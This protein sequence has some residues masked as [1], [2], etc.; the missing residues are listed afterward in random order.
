MA[1]L[2]QMTKQLFQFSDRH[3]RSRLLLVLLLLANVGSFVGLSVAFQIGR[4][5]YLALGSV[6]TLGLLLLD[7]LVMLTW[8]TESRATRLS[9]SVDP[10]LVADWKWT[11]IALC[12][13]VFAF[14]TAGRSLVYYLAV[15]SFF[16]ALLVR[17]YVT[18]EVKESVVVELGVLV[19][20]TA[21]MLGAETLSVAYYARTADTIYHTALATRIAN[22][23]TLLAIAATR[24]DSLPAYH[25]M[26]ALGID[27]TGLPPRAFT[28]VF[29]SLAFAV[30]IA[31]FYVV[32][33]NVTESQTAGL[34]GGV[35]VAVNPEFIYWGTQSHVQSLSFVFLSILL[36]FLSKVADDRGY[37]LASV[38]LFAVWVM[39]H[40]L[41]VFMAIVLVGGPVAFVFVLTK[42]Q[43]SSF[44]VDP[45]RV[46]LK[47][48]ALLVGFTVVYW[49]YAGIFRTPISW[50]TEHSPGSKGVESTAILIQYYSDPVELVTQALPTIIADLHY[51]FWI[52]LTGLSLWV[53]FRSVDRYHR[54]VPVLVFSLLMA[55][56]YYFPN[57]A[58]VPLRGFAALTRWGVMSLPFLVP[59]I[60]LAL[61]KLKPDLTANSRGAV[62]VGVA[63]ALIVVSLTSG[64][65]NPAITDITGYHK[66]AQSSLDDDTVEAVSFTMTHAPPDSTIRGSSLV[67][68]YARFD[69]WER[70]IDLSRY[71][72]SR[73]RVADGELKSDPGL[74][75]VQVEAFRTKGIKVALENPDSK[76]YEG[77]DDI[78]VFTPVTADDV[79][80]DRGQQNVVYDGDG[81]VITY[82]RDAEQAE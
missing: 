19:A 55:C 36:V 52:A 53:I 9:T 77:V 57:P 42:L 5:R 8:N 72:F 75:V 4:P 28:A 32:I 67:P 17:V 50:L 70:G 61:V 49:T 3:S 18:A 23:D 30:T 74:N 56:V 73:V 21:L 62:A 63:F 65:A 38:V 15:A 2:W 22:F 43:N 13:S 41:S 26:V 82:G 81:T 76:A 47:Y 71:R 54:S 31:G 40:H 37:M 25:T 7:A 59:A 14:T 46:L 34:V 10:G 1:E 27:A 68:Y 60:A 79:R 16:T 12:L 11:A 58:W 24:Y 69:M 20:G 64:F 39:T 6:L 33:R 78:T 51:T 66:G 45:G 44:S 35:L 29:M 48:Y 80:W